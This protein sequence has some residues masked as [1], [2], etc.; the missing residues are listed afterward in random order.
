MTNSRLTISSHQVISS[1]VN[2][3]YVSYTSYYAIGS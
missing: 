2:Q 1:L 3:N